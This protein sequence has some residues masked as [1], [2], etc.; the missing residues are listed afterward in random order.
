MKEVEVML[1]TSHVAGFLFWVRFDA[2]EAQTCNAHV[3]GFVKRRR[4]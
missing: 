3:L 1:Q 2:E 4:K